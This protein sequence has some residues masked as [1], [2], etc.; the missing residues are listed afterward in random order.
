M[1][2]P[3]PRAIPAARYGA[4]LEA[5]RDAL[6]ERGAAALLL[7]AGA[8]L[9]WLTGYAP[10][11][12]ERL[13]MLMVPLDEP[14]TLLVPRL[15]TL[16]GQ[17]SPAVGAGLV[18]LSAW[19]ETEDPYARV[20]D[21]LPLAATRLGASLLVSQP[22]WAVHLLRLQAALPGA[23]WELAS[24]ILRELRMVK[25]PDEIELL[26]A[27]AHAADEVVLAIAGGRLVGRTEADVAREVRDR[28]LDAGHEEAAFSIVGSGPYS[29]EPHHEAGGRLIV[30]G[31]P[32]VLDIGGVRAGYCS[33]TTRT[34]WPTAGDPGRGPDPAFRKLYR[35]LQEAQAAATAAV[36]PGV[37][38]EA[39]D[40]L[41]RKAIAAAGFG[42]NFIHRTGH[43]IGLEVHEEPYLVAGNRERLAVGH[44]F[45]VE[46][47]I[48]LD[49]R[50]GARIEDIVVCGP[51]G[52]DVLNGTSRDLYVVNGA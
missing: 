29:A 22:L 1:T 19:E 5:A 35:V 13:T 21:A 7:G 18:T 42:P 49:G 43:G 41:A 8:E 3:Q 40:A 4:R 47:G 30:A 51:D 39:L 36:R 6:R 45:S 34:L 46:P 48:Y 20:R 27:A 31:E 23:R 16:G 10:L 52:P 33:D 26:R 38:C 12:L 14:A 50:H 37:S 44:A 9:R 17:E 24:T 11:P 28:L 25:D 32:I 15:E 2:D